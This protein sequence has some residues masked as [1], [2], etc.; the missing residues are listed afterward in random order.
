MPT[1]NIKVKDKIAKQVGNERYICGNSDFTVEFEFDS[2]WDAY[3]TKTA[4][5]RY[6]GV[7]QE[8][9]FTGNS[10]PVPVIF[11]AGAIAIGVYAGD[12]RTTTAAIVEARHSI[13]DG[14]HV[15][16]VPPDLYEELTGQLED[17]RKQVEA[18]IKRIENLEQGGGGGG[19]PDEPDIPDVPDVPVKLAVPSI[20][21]ESDGAVKLTAPTIRLDTGD[22]TDDDSEYTPAILGVAILGRT[23]LGMTGD[24]VPTI[25]KLT[26]PSIRIESVDD[27][28]DEPVVPEIPKLTAPTIKL[29]TVVYTLDAPEIELVEV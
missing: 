26:A 7:Y 19:T 9:V 22:D 15:Q 23:I 18:L 10:C 1:I 4:R 14:D 17:L 21:I 16:Y 5:F 24:Y 2:E 3:P 11:N 28:E 25:P 13:L 27:G 8:Q 20:R 6:D 29:E 12:L